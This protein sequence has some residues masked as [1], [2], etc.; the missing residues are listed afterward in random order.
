[1]LIANWEIYVRFLAIFLLFFTRR[2]FHLQL[3]N[4]IQE[5]PHSVKK[6]YLLTIATLQE[7]IA[8]VLTIF[9]T[10]PLQFYSLTRYAHTSNIVKKTDYYHFCRKVSFWRARYVS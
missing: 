4:I 7:K 5:I 10:R 1:M 3:S 9:C 6:F 2:S 8:I